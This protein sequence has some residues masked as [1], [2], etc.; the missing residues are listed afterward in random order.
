MADSVEWALQSMQASPAAYEDDQPQ[1][2]ESEK[3][4]DDGIT[5]ERA[6][7]NAEFLFALGSTPKPK[8][9]S[10]SSS[11]PVPKTP[12]PSQLGEVVSPPVW[13]SPSEAGD[14][15]SVGTGA[16]AKES[17]EPAGTVGAEPGRAEEG[18][19]LETSA[20]FGN[21]PE[22]EKPEETQVEEV[23]VGIGPKT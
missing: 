18:V 15:G 1:S 3:W 4:P 14:A 12:Q 17:D 20:T 22:V 16:Q 11:D 6:E 9:K 8:A 13:G 21:G 2:W 7:E 10:G 5:A 23:P 19:S